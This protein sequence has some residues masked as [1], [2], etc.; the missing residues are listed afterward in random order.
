M[1]K[2]CLLC[3]LVAIASF[4]AGW[5]VS[6]T[7]VE[8]KLVDSFGFEWTEEDII[9]NRIWANQLLDLTYSLKQTITTEQWDSIK[10]T[11]EYVVFAIHSEVNGESVEC[12]GL[13]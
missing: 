2:N 1:K 4:V 9:N 12:Y 5:S 7:K 11:D 6:P 8:N 10:L 3:T 13:E